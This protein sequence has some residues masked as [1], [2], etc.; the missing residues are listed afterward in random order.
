MDDKNLKMQHMNDLSH[1]VNRKIDFLTN[2]ETINLEPLIKAKQGL[3]IS[4][5]Y[6]K[7]LLKNPVDLSIFLTKRNQ[8]QN[9][10]PSLNL[11]KNILEI[12]N[13]SK[14]TFGEKK[15]LKLKLKA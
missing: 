10:D 7:F 8:N 1:L 5:L 3:M 12:C 4:S 9:Y 14:T 6:L 11:T 15:C 13:Q 2:Q